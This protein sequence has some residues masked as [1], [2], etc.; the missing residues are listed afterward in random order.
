MTRK[1]NQSIIG[2][3]VRFFDH[4]ISDESAGTIIDS[5]NAND[6]DDKYLYYYYLIHVPGE[7]FKKV[8]IDDVNDFANKSNNKS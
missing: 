1:Q 8:K 3:K 2:K 4:E 6:Y 5:Y 7:G